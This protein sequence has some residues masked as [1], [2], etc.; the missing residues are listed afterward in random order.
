MP[1]PTIAV[2]APTVRMT[3]MVNI[4]PFGGRE[5]KFVTSRNIKVRVRGWR[6][7]GATTGVAARQGPSPSQNLWM[8]DHSLSR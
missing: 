4:S 5:G 1:L 2:E 8:E 3:F 6:G 7:I